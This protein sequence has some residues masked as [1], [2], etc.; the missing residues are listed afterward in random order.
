MGARRHVPAILGAGPRRGSDDALS[1]IP[2]GVSFPVR[3]GV[4]FALRWLSLSGETGKPELALEPIQHGR[5]F[6]D[7]IEVTAVLDRLD[8]TVEQRV[9]SKN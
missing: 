9:I 7:C 4:E 3:S 2:V 6:G 1:K 5:D 8:R